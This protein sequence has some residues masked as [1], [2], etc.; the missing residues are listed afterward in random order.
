MSGADVKHDNLILI[1][2][3]GPDMGCTMTGQVP[4]AIERR[5]QDA[6]LIL[7]SCYYCC[8]CCCRRCR[9]SCCLVLVD[10]VFVVMDYW[11]ACL[12]VFNSQPDDTCLLAVV[13][14]TRV[15]RADFRGVPCTMLSGPSDVSRVHAGCVS[16]RLSSRRAVARFTGILLRKSRPSKCPSKAAKGRKDEEGRVECWKRSRRHFDTE[17]P[18]QSSNNL[19]D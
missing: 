14:C 4:A 15:S 2:L 13:P 6:I 8:C 3:S 17:R 5:L 18:L 12:T 9:C 16:F 19:A 1:A 10:R 11:E 7:Q